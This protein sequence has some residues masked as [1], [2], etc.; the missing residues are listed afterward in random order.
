MNNANENEKENKMTF[1]DK[2]KM[3]Q[4]MS[5][6]N[7][8]KEEKINFKPSYNLKIENNLK[9]EDANIKNNETID[10]NENNKKIIEQNN[11]KEKNDSKIK[12][13]AFQD[14]LNLIQQKII[15]QNDKNN[16][17]NDLNKEKIENENL[18]NDIK[19]NT[20]KE[21][22]DETI[23]VEENK[24]TENENIEINTEIDNNS[25]EKDLYENEENENK[26]K[27]TLLE[28]TDV[29]EKISEKLSLIEEENENETKEKIEEKL[30]IKEDYENIDKHLDVNIEKKVEID[31]SKK[32]QKKEQKD[33]EIKIESKVKEN[34][35]KNT[36]VSKDM[37]SKTK[38]EN[39]NNIKSEFTNTNNIN[40]NKENCGNSIKRRIAEMQKLYKNKKEEP[41][42]QHRFK[43]FDTS[44]LET[45][46]IFRVPKEKKEKE[47][48]HQEN[49]IINKENK[50]ISNE[51]E[52]LKGQNDEDNDSD[53]T[54]ELNL[55]KIEE[56]EKEDKKEEIIKDE[57]KEKEEVKIIE[58]ENINI[59]EE[60]KTEEN[61]K[62]K[63]D[64]IEEPNKEENN[65]YEKNE[66][67]NNI[68]D[69]G[70][71]ENYNNEKEVENNTKEKT[72]I[73]N[74]NKFQMFANSLNEK[75]LGRKKSLKNKELLKGKEDNNEGTENI[76]NIDNENNDNNK[77]SNIINDINEKTKENNDNDNNINKLSYL[78]NIDNESNENN[79]ENEDNIYNNI[80]E[81]QENN[82]LENEDNYENENIIEN[83]KKLDD[84][85]IIDSNESNNRIDNDI[86][87]DKDE[88]DNKIDKNNLIENENNIKEKNN[89]KD[90]INNNKIK[91]KNIFEFE[92]ND[93]EINIENESDNNRKR[94]NS[95][96]GKTLLLQKTTCFNDLN[97]NP[98]Y[99]SSSDINDVN[100]SYLRER[101][102]T[103]FNIQS[104]TNKISLG[105]PEALIEDIFLEKI[106]IN[107]DEPAKN[108]TFCEC[109]FLSS[110]SKENGK[111]MEKS[112]D[113]KAECGHFLCSY[114]PAMQPEIIYKY[115]KDDIK[116]LEINCLAA[117]ICFTNGI[118]VCYEENEDTIKTV[119]NYRSS[120]TNQVGD[121]FFAV[122]YHF[123]LKM[124]NS[125]FENLYTVT[126]IKNKLSNY[127]D[128]LNALFSEELPGEVL[129]K[130]NIYEKMNM[131]E[132][133]Y[134]PFCLCL[135]S[136]YPFIE[137]MEKCLESIM[138]SINNID[139]NNIDELNKI[140]TYIVKSIPTPPKHSKVY[141]PLPY[142]NKFIDIEYPYY[143]DIN[144]FCDNPLIILYYLSPS[145]ILCLFKLLIFEQ[146]ILIV[147]KDN[148]DIAKVILN[149]ASLLYPF[150][151]IHTYIPIMSEKMV[152]FLQ[153]F[154]PF[155][156][157]INFTLLNRAKHI[158]EKASKEVFIINIDEDKIEL[159]GNYQNNKPTKA[160][161]YI[162]KNFQSLPKNVENLILKELKDIKTNH[163]KAKDGYDKYN[164]NLKIKNL[165][166]YVFVELLQDYKKYSYVIDDYPVFNS[167]LMI[168]EKKNDK[169]FFKEFTSTQIFQM[170]I[171]KSLF[172]DKDKRTFF[173]ELFD[174]FTDMKKKK[175]SSNNIYK[176]LY[177]YFKKD[178]NEYFKIKKNYIIK[179]FFIKEFKKYEEQFKKKNKTMK[180]NNITVFLS[181]QYEQQKD[182][183]INDHGVLRENRRIIKNPIYLTNDKDPK[184]YNIFLISKKQ[185]NY[186]IDD[187]T[188]METDDIPKKTLSN[189]FKFISDEN[190][191]NNNEIRMKRITSNDKELTEDDLDDIKENIREIMSRIY[192][193][194]V[195]KIEKDKAKLMEYLMSYYGI[196][197]F[198]SIL[199]TGNIEKR[200]V[201]IVIEES[202]DFFNYVIFNTLLN[203][204]KLEENNQNYKIAVKLLKVCLCIKTVKNKKEMFLSDDLFSKF[205][206]YAYFNNLNFWKI[207]IEDDFTKSDIEE[208]KKY[209]SSTYENEYIYIDEEDENYKLYLKHSRV[210][211]EE[212]LCTMIKMKF[213]KSFIMLKITDLIKEYII[214]ENDLSKLMNK[215]IEDLE[216]YKNK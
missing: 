44:F 3:F 92:I 85:N 156:T 72:K 148:D 115:P 216:I 175:Y 116:G 93:D 178:Y 74:F 144:E 142:F 160:A 24:K 171:Q 153:S 37:K 184:I 118:K 173:D 130:L 62:Y 205:E 167:V 79:K 97:L 34:N 45:I 137:P 139:Q 109:F 53:N 60:E 162:K 150:D 129:N 196:Y 35:N 110:F 192:K 185:L 28:Q 149:F 176:K 54:K 90:S 15:F 182:N 155:F 52:I 143:R 63:K 26:E 177:D 23:S 21:A 36:I 172:K 104:T 147:G 141:F 75:M 197:Y 158:L 161:S 111:L 164:A 94:K 1:K 208:L 43:K 47:K 201:K 204:L 66:V 203:I 170:F 38:K 120:F 209:K 113:N 200:A 168:K 117:S 30:N 188:I 206:D 133:V 127:E 67:I 183:N 132:N 7:E 108:D 4:D 49:N 86:L 136:R 210:I 195:R 76:I 169:N 105:K 124:L 64:D 89:R 16:N 9:I 174:K 191:D 107:Q 13:T 51:K 146:K 32:E 189:R 11:A 59:N 211:I 91:E 99:N 56:S 102:S 46:K 123:Y 101:K 180:L 187:E 22:K 33:D 50:T 165:F 154:L 215:I 42:E 8:K 131:K 157:G 58:N 122:A 73:K 69:N 112:E 140:I 121:R 12:S 163:I 126:P 41:K 194:D 198:A 78:N 20:S 61:I 71:N 159:N 80:D 190:G 193:S 114:L 18:G 128:E 77:D 87:I 5:K 98:V 125:E 103:V 27:I 84:D 29:E 186:N 166:F 2:L 96:E 138:M 179:P 25:I 6:N 65:N 14:K 95:F 151:W 82:N 134:I 17:N 152:K 68:E 88:R 40:I 39:D 19:D 207:W 55:N 202:Y 70:I 83:D 145:N 213:Q 81:P 119:K 106:N 212:L 181:K 48:H 10:Q 199:N 100:G 31:I 214:N 135:V 57:D